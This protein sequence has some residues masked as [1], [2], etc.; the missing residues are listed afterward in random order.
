MIINPSLKS[1]LTLT[2]VI[3]NLESNEG[4]LLLDFRD[5]NDQKLKDFTKIIIDK[6]C[7]ITM[8]ELRPGKYSFKYFHDMNNNKKLDTY[9]IGA[10]KEG[11]GFSNN[12]KGRFGFPDFAKTIFEIVNDTT[13][14][15]TPDY[16][17]F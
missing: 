13:I 5:S 8:N 15:C 4:S 3:K 14:E 1:Q 11:F 17:K 10:P 2:I 6:Q 7:I 12:V 16:F 9:W